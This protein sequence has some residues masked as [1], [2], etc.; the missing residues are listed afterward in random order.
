MYK[1]IFQNTFTQ[2]TT[3]IQHTSTQI[4]HTSIFQKQDFVVQNKLKAKS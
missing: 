1:C 4:Q 3:Q 2:H